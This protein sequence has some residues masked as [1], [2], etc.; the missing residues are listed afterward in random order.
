MK[1]LLRGPISR[2]MTIKKFTLTA[3][4]IHIAHRIVC[5][6]QNII[7]LWTAKRTITHYL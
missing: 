1:K 4:R 5:A 2:S 6:R 3:V 7:N